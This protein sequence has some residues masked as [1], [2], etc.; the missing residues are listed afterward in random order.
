M[1]F[2]EE[3][4]GDVLVPFTGPMIVAGQKI[5]ERQIEV[6]SEEFAVMPVGDHGVTRITNDIDDFW[7]GLVAS[8]VAEKNPRIGQLDVLR[9]RAALG[10]RQIYV[11]H[12][13]GEGV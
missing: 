10:I 8:G 13:F 3:P 7:K 12:I 1:A 5:G 11:R 2:L 6:G 4:A 9:E